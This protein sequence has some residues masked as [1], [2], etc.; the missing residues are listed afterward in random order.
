MLTL[1]SNLRRIVLNV[2]VTSLGC[3]MVAGTAQAQLQT[4]ASKKTSPNHSA[5]EAG[6]A[7]DVT[8]S[9]RRRSE[10][11]QKV[12]VATSVYSAKQ[13]TRDNV[14]D[15]QGIFE[16]I[17]SAN[18]RANSS[19]KDR[20][21]FVRGI[22]TIATSPGVEPSVSTVLDGVVLARPGQATADILDLDHVEV[23]R[24]P[25]GT[26]FG[27][28]ASAGAVNIV[29]R[30][31]TADFH[32]FAEASY[33]SGNEYRLTGGATGTLVPSKLVANASFLVGGFD[34]NV[35]NLANSTTVNGYEHRGARS[36]FLWTPDEET[37]VTFG[38]DYMYQNDLVPTGVYTSTNQVAYPTG[39]VKTNPALASALVG[40]GV[41]PSKNNTSV[42][43]NTQSRSVDHTGGFSATVDRELGR[44]YKLTSISAYRQWQNIQDQDYDGL[45]GVY[46]TLPEVRDHGKLNFWQASQEVRIASPRGHFFDYV[47]GFYYLHGVDRE[48]YSRTL[49]Q[50]GQGTAY[51]QSHYGITNNNYAVFAEGNL[52]FTKNFRAILGL[53]LLRDDLGYDMSRRSTSAVAVTGIRPSYASSGSTSQN[54]YVDRIGLQYD[55]KPDIH[56]YFTYSHGY[57]GPAY[58]TFFNMQATDAQVLKPEQNNSFELGLKSQFLHRRVTANLAAFIE[59]FSNYQANFLDN[60]AGGAVYRMINAGSVSS[61]GVEGDV[62]VRT[63]PGL[64]LGGNFAYTY[65]VVDK[66]NCPAGAP[67]SCNVNG[68]PLPF[69]PRWKFV[70]NAD[71]TKSLNNRFTLSV[72]SDYTWQS[73]TQF[74]LTETPDTVQKAYGI[75][76]MSTTLQDK[77]LKLQLSLVMRNAINTHYA[78]YMAYGALGG[79]TSSIPRDYGR[80]GGF[81]LR[82]DF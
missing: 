2:S 82:K 1:P 15:L 19:S 37:Q 43:N 79:V 12:P 48:V 71:Y 68:Q 27:K 31:P 45:S 44:G 9:V 22:G 38:L 7:E 21:T 36:K 28:N 26:L 81:V 32:A 56:A 62:A 74:A 65:A 75:W 16:F 66:F 42:S 24:G 5:L 3:A 50:N 58:N 13:A 4:L 53:R 73:R 40:E 20:A 8:V 10:P 46:A 61:K 67:A 76:N 14:H 39:A 59:N 55:I 41:T 23:M 64:T 72:D 57:K 25:Q 11:L 47:A 77:K 70:L 63:L 33:F 80:Y 17:P 34:G 35:K 18:F 6:Q 69:A 49:S 51:G 52:N 29:T 78:S 60:V 30:Q 54:G